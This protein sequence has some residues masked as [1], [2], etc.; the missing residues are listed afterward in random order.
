MERMQPARPGVLRKR[1]G[2]RTSDINKYI[3]FYVINGRQ[4][5]AFIAPPPNLR[6][7]FQ[8]NRY[9]FLQAESPLS[10]AALGS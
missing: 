10:L 1:Q 9:G 6:H 3:F 7:R 4:E 5:L 8:H 2:R